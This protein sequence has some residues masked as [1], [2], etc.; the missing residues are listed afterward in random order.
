MGMINKFVGG[1]EMKYEEILGKLNARE[2]E[3]R[4]AHEQ[5]VS[6]IESVRAQW[7][8]KLREDAKEVKSSLAYS[9]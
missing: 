4:I 9:K 3:L 2:L 7:A 6:E 1:K 8:R 5:V